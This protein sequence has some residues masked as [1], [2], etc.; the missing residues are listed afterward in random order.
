MI[1][2]LDNLPFFDLDLLLLILLLLN[3]DINRGLLLLGDWNLL[4][5]S[6]SNIALILRSS[7]TSYLLTNLK[8]SLLGGVPSV[9][10][11]HLL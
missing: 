7:V 3:S 6:L 8:R 5:L 1:V 9:S 4:N 2:L 10:F 11:E